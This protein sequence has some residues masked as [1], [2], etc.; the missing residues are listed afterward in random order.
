MPTEVA[1][2]SLFQVKKLHLW[3][4]YLPPRD[5]RVS[6]GLDLV[7]KLEIKRWQML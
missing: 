5:N 7:E 6:E 1:M 4:S 3:E 2:C